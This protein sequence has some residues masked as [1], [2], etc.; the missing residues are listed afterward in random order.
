MSVTKQNIDI[1]IQYSTAGPQH[2]KQLEY[3]H[4]FI[5][6]KYEEENISFIMHS[7]QLPKRRRMV[8][9]VFLQ[10]FGLDNYF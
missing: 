8:S 6:M 7:Q 3:F 5:N 10:E 4:G 9:L 2:V 1:D